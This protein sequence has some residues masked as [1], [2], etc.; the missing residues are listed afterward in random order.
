MN[1]K[2][3]EPSMVDIMSLIHADVVHE[4]APHTF[5][6]SFWTVIQSEA[7]CV[8]LLSIIREL[9]L[10]NTDID[11]DS[12]LKSIQ[13]HGLSDVPASLLATVLGDA[14]LCEIVFQQIY[15]EIESGVEEIIQ[16]AD[17]KLVDQ[18]GRSFSAKLFPTISPDGATGW[19]LDA[20]EVP[21]GKLDLFVI[22]RGDSPLQTKK[23]ASLRIP[24]SHTNVAINTG[25][26]A[27]KEKTESDVDPAERY[28]RC[29][30]AMGQVGADYRLEGDLEGYI[31]PQPNGARVVALISR[32]L[33]RQM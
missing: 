20:S 31:I 23:I 14:K 21:S 17:A 15:P 33:C 11:R 28:T 24:P 27:G 4:F 9:G 7:A 32:S 12:V 1:D 6:Q 16:L 8:R 25:A 19:L 10:E 2:T 26:L 22:R 5:V 18:R 30:Q 3:T 29:K 13:E